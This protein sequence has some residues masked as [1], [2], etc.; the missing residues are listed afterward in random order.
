[1]RRQRKRLT[2]RSPQRMIGHQPRQGR[3]SDRTGTLKSSGWA[4]VSAPP[5]R[6]LCWSSNGVSNPT[7]AAQS[8]SNGL[9]KIRPSNPQHGR[10]YSLI[11]ELLRG[12]YP[13][14]KEPPRLNDKTTRFKNWQRTRIGVSPEQTYKQPRGRQKDAPKHRAPCGLC[15]LPYVAPMELNYKPTTEQHSGNTQIFKKKPCAHLNNSCIKEEITQQ[16]RKY[17]K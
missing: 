8:K 9:P 13:G 4:G 5:L 17:F 16:T 11:T 6:P 10:K 1:M 12:A 7:R 14:Y 15:E 3:P 2:E